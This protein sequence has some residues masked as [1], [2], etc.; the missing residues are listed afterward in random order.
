MCRCLEVWVVPRLGCSGAGDNQIGIG[1][2]V[3]IVAAKVQ[4]DVV[5]EVADLF[6][7]FRELVPG[8]QVGEQDLGALVDEPAEHPRPT[9]EVPEPHDGDACGV[10]VWHWG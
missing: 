5:G 3:G 2:V 7:R 6:E 9:A 4:L 1:E 10:E 8:A